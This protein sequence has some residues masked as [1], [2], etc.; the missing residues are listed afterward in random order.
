MNERTAD[1][2]LE[3]KR[4]RQRARREFS[5]RQQSD[6][7]YRLG[8]LLDPLA[9]ARVQ[10]ALAAEYRRLFKAEDTKN[11]STAAQLYADA[12]RG[13]GDTQG[14]KELGQGRPWSW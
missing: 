14:R 4:R 9:G 1:Q 7:M 12:S 10:D 11:R 6:G 5:I 3:K 2:D 13:S 8:G